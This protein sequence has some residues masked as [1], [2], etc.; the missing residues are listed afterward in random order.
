MALFPG[1]RVVP[2]PLPISNGE[3]ISP[4]A[5]VAT[6]GAIT[7]HALITSRK[8][9]CGSIEFDCTLTEGHGFANMIPGVPV[10]RG[11]TENDTIIRRPDRV[12]MVA[13]VS[14]L[15]VTFK[16]QF[17]LFASNFQQ[18]FREPFSNLS[19]RETAW[20][21]IQALNDSKEVFDVYTHIAL[22]PEMVF[23]SVSFIEQGTSDLQLRIVVRKFEQV[24]VRLQ[25]YLGGQVTDLAD[26]RDDIGVQGS[27]D[28][29]QGAL[30][31][32]E[33]LDLGATEVA[34]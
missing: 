15:A 16:D 30:G 19:K 31:E 7:A 25:S 6:A 23:E 26:E 4:V 9:S 22:Y 18:D 12:T 11:V 21:R 20:A 1:S 5:A 14:D 33:P 32:K 17:A 28:V 34:A 2:N 10:Q 29:T 24:N 27:K 13:I 8:P 3:V